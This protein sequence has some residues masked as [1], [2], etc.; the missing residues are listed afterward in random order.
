[1][2]WGLVVLRTR[3]SGW[4]SSSAKARLYSAFAKQDMTIGSRFRANGLT[5]ALDSFTTLSLYSSSTYMMIAMS[6][7]L[8]SP[9]AIF[10]MNNFGKVTFTV[11]AARHTRL[12]FFV[13]GV[14]PN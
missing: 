9:L 1:M 7:T 3:D 12:L 2:L 13:V 6:E 8:L 14:S 5:V 11:T 4:G 10:A